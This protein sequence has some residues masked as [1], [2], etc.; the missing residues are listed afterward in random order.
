MEFPDISG[1]SYRN[2]RRCKQFYSFYN[3]EDKIRAQVVRELNDNSLFSIP[4]GHP[5]FII[6]RIKSP[7]GA[8]FIFL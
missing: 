7:Q 6:G 4:W 8:L 3:Q 5:I 1:F 2:L